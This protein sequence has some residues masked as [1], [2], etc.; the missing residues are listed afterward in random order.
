MDSST[1]QPI[2]VAHPGG[3]VADYLES[4]GWSQ[5]DLAR[6]TGITPKTIS[7]ICNEKAPI[8]PTTALAFEKVLGRPAHFWINLQSR[9][10]EAKARSEQAARS[11]QWREWMQHFPIA[12]MK[13][14]QWLPDDE[15][16]E[17]ND[18]SA[19]LRFLG[20]SSPDSWNSTWNA[21]Q[22]AYRQ[23]RKFKTSDYAISAWMR[24]VEIEAEEI[25]TERYHEKGL[26]S[27][28]SDFRALTRLRIDEALPK[29]RAIA[30]NHGVAFVWVPAL[31]ET[32]I[33]GCT[34]WVNRNKVIVALSLRYKFDDQI[35]FTFF[36]ELGHVLLHRKHHNFILDNADDNLADDV[37]D[38]DMQKVEDEANRFAAD[39]L[40]PPDLLKQFL[41]FGALESE[42]IH[43][44]SEAVNIAPGVVIGR[45][46]RE[47]VLAYHQGNSLKQKIEWSFN[48][49]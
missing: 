45:L 28:L 26:I 2:S 6:R 18:L 32:G 12:E 19:L 43:E 33:S 11:S 35:W 37:V 23:T 25:E 22:I 41:S 5:G 46:Q 21:A 9:Y 29:A 49:V 20:V 15:E 8:S 42:H 39:T 27:A 4:F 36:H 16:S 44:F 30:A 40:I 13:K 38:P 24:A 10:E 48:E 3:T 31:P 14:R 1:Y 34:R 17:T 47:G 7:E